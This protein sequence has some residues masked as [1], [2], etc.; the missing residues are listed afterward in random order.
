[1]EQW[2]VYCL[3]QNV[4]S[5]SMC[6]RER[7]LV[8]V[9]RHSRTWAASISESSLVCLVVRSLMLL[10]SSMSIGEA[11]SSLTMCFVGPVGAD[12]DSS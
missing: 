5:P 4:N 12:G 6:R 3:C 2:L 11:C 8:P 1:M 9:L 7:N 10:I